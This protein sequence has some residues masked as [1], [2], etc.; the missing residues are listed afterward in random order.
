MRF[1][2]MFSS[3]RCSKRRC[4]PGHGGTK[5]VDGLARC[6]LAA[7]GLAGS[8]SCRCGAGPAVADVATEGIVQ[9]LRGGC[10]AIN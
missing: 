7:L 9:L 5:K 3:Q 1:L 10:K 6:W 4:S 2:R 8:A